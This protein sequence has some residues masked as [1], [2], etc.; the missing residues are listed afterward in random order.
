MSRSRRSLC[1]LILLAPLALASCGRAEPT[2]GRR[3]RM[4]STTSLADTG[5][6]GEL[7]PAFEKKTGYHVD[8][9]SVGSGKALEML[10][11][12]SADVAITHA[13]AEEQA[14]I[15][16]GAAG[17][18]TPFMHNEFVLVGPKDGIGVVAGAGDIWEAL[19]R[20]AAS[21]RKFV[22]RGD[23]SGTHQREQ[24][25][26]QGAGIAPDAAFIVRAN[27]GM[28]TALECASEEAAFT[29]VD[30]STFQVKQKGLK[31]AIVFQGDE[32]L[33]NTYSVI[34]PRPGSAGNTQGAA[35]LAAFVTSA[36]GRALIGAFGVQ[37]FGE[38]LF[39]PERR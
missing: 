14:A 19:R 23:G 11:D 18:R 13:P 15:T 29:L 30:R 12:G 38:P 10:R 33:R 26:W 2:G 5:L 39:T 6:L 28:G 9:S 7:L 1:A 32:G 3:L 16:A 22:S 36:E 31:L 4:A 27:A 24:A 37:A 35:A 20:V 8:V 21:G 25:L 34:E 17:T